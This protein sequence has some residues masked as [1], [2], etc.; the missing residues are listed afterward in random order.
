VQSFADPYRWGSA[1]RYTHQEY[2]DYNRPY[3][4]DDAG[5]LRR[6]WRDA[7]KAIARAHAAIRRDRRVI[8]EKREAMYEARR[9]H[10][11][12]AYR[13]YQR[14]LEQA[15]EALRRHQEQLDYAK[16][17]RNYERYAFNRR[18]WR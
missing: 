11:W 6:D 13:H 10:D 17:E 5:Q 12:G 8:Q 16:R 7:H 1:D 9:R 18:D 4:G 3:Y 14:E 15:K 2:S